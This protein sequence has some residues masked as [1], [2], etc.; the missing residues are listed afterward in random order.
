MDGLLIDTEKL[1][2]RFWLEAA[3]Q[4]GY[5]MKD[6]HAKAIRALAAEF[7]APLLRKEV[8]PDFDYDKVRALRR[9]LM[10]EYTDENGVEEKKGLGELLTYLHEH[11]IKTAIATASGIERTTRYLTFLNRQNDFDKIVCASMVKRGKPEPDIYLEAARQLGVSPEECVALEDSPNG[12]MAA[13]RAGCC[14]IM[15]PDLT[16]PDEEIR[17]IIYACVPDLAA[18]IPI[19]ETSI[20]VTSSM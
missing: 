9:K 5:P 14:P 20:D 2:H 4:L 17:K 8:C 1:Y 3:H 11:H 19:L 7:A 13:K 16:Q 18:V 15:V 6:E 12:L 10:K